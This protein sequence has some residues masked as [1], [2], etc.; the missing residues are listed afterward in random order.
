MKGVWDRVAVG[1]TFAAIIA[2]LLLRFV[3]HWHGL[4]PA[5]PLWIA[6]AI[7]GIPLIY[8][9]IVQVWHRKFG[10]D[11]LAGISIVTAVIVGELLVAA[12]IILMLTG[13]QA[14]ERYATGRAS[15]VLEALAKRTPSTAHRIESGKIANIAVEA[16]RIG[17]QLVIYPHEICPWMAR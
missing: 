14:L 1:I 3:L 16:I 9:L 6:V 13:G 7:C 4:T 11:F 5:L 8:D 17:D 12:I 2:H 15:S 10:A